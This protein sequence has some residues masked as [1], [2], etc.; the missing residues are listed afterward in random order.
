MISRRLP[1]SMLSASRHAAA[2]TC[3]SD[4]G[5]IRSRAAK[6]SSSYRVTPRA[7]RT[8]AGGAGKPLC[9][10]RCAAAASKGRSPNSAV[11]VVL[12]QQRAQI[13]PVPEAP[14]IGPAQRDP[15]Q[16]RT[17]TQNEFN[18]KAGGKRAP[19]EII[20]AR[21]QFAP[22]LEP[23]APISERIGLAQAIEQRD[24]IAFA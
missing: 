15:P 10:R 19:R 8:R 20:D 18:H 24:R 12:G 16:R 23:R 21:S 22:V 9:A 1:C 11:I 17:S 4:D 14:A 2:P 13:K 5:G 3:A 7:A 6:S